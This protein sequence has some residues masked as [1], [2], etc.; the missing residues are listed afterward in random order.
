[1]SSVHQYNEEG[2]RAGEIPVPT[3]LEPWF[4]LPKNDAL[5]QQVVVAA[6]AEARSPVAHTKIRSEVRGGGAKPWRQ[7]K[8]GQA[9]HGSR[10]SPIWVGGGTTFGPRSDKQYA[11]SVN[12]KMARKALF[13]VLSRKL[14]E[15]R[16]FSCALPSF[17]QPSTKQA[18]AFMRHMQAACPGAV[19]LVFPDETRH[20]FHMSIR[21]IPSVRAC[22]AH[23]LNA[24]TAH[25]VSCVVFV[26]PEKVFAVLQTRTP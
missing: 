10:R 4:S 26:E 24:H 7:K 12:K 11:V 23:A 3:T 13:T 22:S 2:V 20:N 1:M 6:Q 19:L 17:E 15:Q 14:E 5:V 21:N 18:S 8:T 16:L 25:T 9:R